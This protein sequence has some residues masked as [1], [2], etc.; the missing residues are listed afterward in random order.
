M[1][2]GNFVETSKA[3]LLCEGRCGDKTAQHGDPDILFDVR[4]V[5]TLHEFKQKQP[6]GQEGMSFGGWRWIYGCTQC[7]AFRTWGVEAPS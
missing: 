6:I 7:G 1:S 3:L 5:A 4:H 2:G